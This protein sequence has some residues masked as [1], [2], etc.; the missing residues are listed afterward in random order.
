MKTNVY[1]LG[2]TIVSVFALASCST[3]DKLSTGRTDRLKKG[4]FYKTYEAN[5]LPDASAA[6]GLLPITVQPNMEEDDFWYDRDHTLLVELTDSISAK[7]SRLPISLIEIS[8]YTLV[9]SKNAPGIYVGS[10]EGDNVPAGASIVR[11]DHEKYPPMIIYKSK[12]KDD[13]KV[14]ASN[15]ASEYEAEYLL[16]I[17]ISF[18]QYPKSDKGLVKKK[19][20]LGT[21][22]EPEIRFFSSEDKPVEVLQLSGYLTDKNGTVLR[23]GAEGVIYKDTPFWQ[24]VLSIEEL[25]DDK[26]LAR[27]LHEERREDL[28][29]NPLVL[30]VAIENLISQLLDRDL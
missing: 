1:V 30:D 10:S 4:E 17:W 19:V 29:G 12:A 15:T 27:L 14:A 23:A 22:Y 24:Q 3:L 18:A 20:I 28:P 11:E 6:I 5:K 21:N 25:I 7:I 16:R 8:D 2:L 13:W 26:M 9:D